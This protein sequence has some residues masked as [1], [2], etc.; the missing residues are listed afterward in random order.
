M[1]WVGSMTNNQPNQNDTHAL[2]LSQPAFLKLQNNKAQWIDK[3]DRINKHV[4]AP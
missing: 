2:D 1:G 3:G 4:C